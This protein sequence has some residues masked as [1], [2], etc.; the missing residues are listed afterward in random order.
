MVRSIHDFPDALAQPPQA[1]ARQFCRGVR[2]EF[3]GDGTLDE[4]H[5]VFY[6]APNGSTLVILGVALMELSWQADRDRLV[7]HWS[8]TG[9]RLRYNP[10]WMQDAPKFLDETRGCAPELPLTKLSPF[11]AQWYA[12]HRPREK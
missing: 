1:P 4:N 10:P 8:E 6:V 11:G 12:P 5:A 7:C 2:Q 9:E 3:G